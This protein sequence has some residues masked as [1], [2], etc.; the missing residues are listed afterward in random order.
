MVDV[1]PRASHSVYLSRG[2]DLCRCYD[3]KYVRDMS[4]WSIVKARA[5]EDG[6]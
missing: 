2:I 1:F 6:V 5:V 4:R 3:C